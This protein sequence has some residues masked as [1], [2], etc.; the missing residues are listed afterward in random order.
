MGILHKGVEKLGVLAVADVLADHLLVQSGILPEPLSYL[1]GVC[2]DAE[3]A[4]FLQELDP[5][6]WLLVELFCAGN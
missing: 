1:V 5:L 3:E 2:G 4:F 6:L